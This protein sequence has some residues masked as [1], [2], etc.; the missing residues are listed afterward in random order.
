MSPQVNEHLRAF[1]VELRRFAVWEPST[2]EDLQR[3]YDEAN[4]LNTG[5]FASLANQMKHFY[6]HYMSDADIRARDPR[7]KEMQQKE[8]CV[9][10]DELETQV[11]Q[12][13]P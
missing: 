3:W 12:S 1:I 4:E 8:F 9:L 7:H 11:G 6:W 10:I 2:K 5:V 13:K